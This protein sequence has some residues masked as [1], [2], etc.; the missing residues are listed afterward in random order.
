MVKDEIIVTLP[1]IKN[2]PEKPK[3]LNINEFKSVFPKEKP[4]ETIG[5]T[6]WHKDNSQN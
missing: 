6:T 3:E 4:K 2:F 1:I 5:G